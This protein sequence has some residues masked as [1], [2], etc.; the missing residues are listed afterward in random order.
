MGNPPQRQQGKRPASKRSAKPT[1][2][3]RP[4][5]QTSLSQSF[6][7]AFSGIAQGALTQRN[8][9]IHIV[10]AVIA[11]LA[12]AFLRCTVVEWAIVIAFIA[13]VIAAELI[14]TAIEA[15]VDLASPDYHPLAKRAKDVAAG[16]VL[17]LAIAAVIA[18]LIIYISAFAR[19]F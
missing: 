15:L 8:M 19:L 4:S 18:G 16:A 9:R 2:G 10:V 1:T 7:H 11:I 17:V 6:G 3:K 12:C 13:L 14:N 5:S